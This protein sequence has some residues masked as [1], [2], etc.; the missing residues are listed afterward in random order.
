MQKFSDLL[1]Q[2]RSANAYWEASVK[3]DFASQLFQ[4]LHEHGISQKELATRVAVSPSQISQVLAGNENLSVRSMIKYAMGVGQVV[5]VRLMPKEADNACMPASTA[6]E[7][8]EWAKVIRDMSPVKQ[9]ARAFWEQQH[10]DANADNEETF[11]PGTSKMQPRVP[12]AA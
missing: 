8:N 11:C 12:Q 10:W 5:K 2:A 4:I 7:D 9:S 3:H 1:N 6:F